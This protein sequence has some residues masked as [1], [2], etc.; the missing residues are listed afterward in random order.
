MCYDVSEKYRLLLMA[1]YHR[2]YS[3]IGRVTFWCSKEMTAFVTCR[4]EKYTL[5][6]QQSKAAYSRRCNLGSRVRVVTDDLRPGT[7]IYLKAEK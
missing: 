1:V 5:T 4:D 6:Q 2:R 7:A 3:F